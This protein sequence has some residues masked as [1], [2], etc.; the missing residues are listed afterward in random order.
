[1]TVDYK[2]TFMLARI[3]YIPPGWRTKKGEQCP[4]EKW[5]TIYTCG[6]CGVMVIDIIAIHISTRTIAC[7]DCMG[8]N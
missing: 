4:S 7:L 3:D 5:Y 1:M 6:V 2:S 8:Q